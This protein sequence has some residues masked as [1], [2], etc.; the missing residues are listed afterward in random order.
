MYDFFLVF[1][2]GVSQAFTPMIYADETCVLFVH[3]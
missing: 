1:Q 3:C 2:C